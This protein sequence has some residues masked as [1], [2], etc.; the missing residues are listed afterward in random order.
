MQRRLLF[1][2]FVIGLAAVCCVT[3]LAQGNEFSARLSTVPISAAERDRITGGGSATATLDGRRLVISGS[4]RGLQGPATAG[5]LHMSPATGVRGPAISEVG[6]DH[7]TSGSVAGSVELS[8][9]Q[10]QALRDGR[11]YLEI[12]SEAAPEGNLWGWLLE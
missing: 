1:R 11:L 2:V 3:T 6:V 8:R 9:D 4:F 5:A 10:V 7:E 12:A